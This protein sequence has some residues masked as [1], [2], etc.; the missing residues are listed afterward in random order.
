MMKPEEIVS[1][2]R[3]SGLRVRTFHG[4]PATGRESYT[5]KGAIIRIMAGHK[6]LYRHPTYFQPNLMIIGSFSAV[7][8]YNPKRIRDFP[9]TVCYENKHAIRIFETKEKAERY[10]QYL[11]GER[12]K[13]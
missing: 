4:D 3:A 6:E 8:D 12:Q 5:Q 2:A 9:F 1:R 10:V 7:F 11:K 13:C